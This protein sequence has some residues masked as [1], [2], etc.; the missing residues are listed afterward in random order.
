MPNKANK[1]KENVPGPFYVDTD[2]TFC[3]LCIETAPEHFRG[4]DDHAFVYRQ[5]VTADEKA[6]CEEALQGCPTEAIGNDG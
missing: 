1:H 4:A 5:P 2:C 3:E 6:R